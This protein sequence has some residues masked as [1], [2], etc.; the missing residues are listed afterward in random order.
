MFSTANLIIW[1]ITGAV[2]MAYFVY[3]KR[4]EKIPFL[5]AGLVLCVYPYFFESIAALV[6]VGIVLIAYP[7][8]LKYYF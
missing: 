7:F 1:I 5:I 4:Q 2:G 8:V 6:L 3:G